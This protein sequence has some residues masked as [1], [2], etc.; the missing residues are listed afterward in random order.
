M[1]ATSILLI[2]GL[3]FAPL[4]AHANRKS[5]FKKSEFKVEYRSALESFA[6]GLEQDA[7][8]ELIELES[9]SA[10]EAGSDLQPLWKAKLSV[11]RDL[12]GAGPDLLVPVTQLHER[13]YVEYL[14][15]GD[16]SL[17]AH[18]R[19]LTM[20]LAEIYAGRVK[21]EHGE[22]MASAVMTSLA[23]YMQAAFVD[24]TASN[25]YRRAA[26]IDPNNVAARLGLAGILERHGDYDEAIPVLREAIRIDPNSAESR[27]RLAIH[28][29]RVDEIE[30]AEL[31]LRGLVDSPAAAPRWVRSLAFQELTLL[32]IDS[33]ELEQAAALVE[34]AQRELPGD[35]T[36]PILLA[37][38]ADRVGHR[39]SKLA[40]SAALGQAGSV[41]TASP[42]YRYSQMPRQ[43]L[44]E[45]RA[46][47]R[48]ETAAQLPTL[49]AA[50]SDRAQGSTGSR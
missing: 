13:A 30:E 21:D 8:A 47:L 38:A 45:V 17:A 29:V 33:S 40:L 34:S 22:R 10:T 12:L 32:L 4:L 18:S 20:E 46:S 27:L 6:S 7:L 50:L 42:R 41:D 24:S 37:F 36:L 15:R 26:S 11:I 2:L 31:L 28:L 9:R 25:L 44:E 16:H 39:S 49:A 19:T 23:G 14:S 48:G 3:L 1:R 35:P 5:S 43:E